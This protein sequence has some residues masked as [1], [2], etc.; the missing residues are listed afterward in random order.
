MTIT[1]AV[2]KRIKDLLYKN[3]MSQYRLIKET[4]LDKSTIQSILKLKTKDIKV[5]T[6]IL[7]SYAFNIYIYEFFNCEYFEPNNID[8]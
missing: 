8:I 7:I 4:C 1:E 2:A 6:I 5:S 3:N